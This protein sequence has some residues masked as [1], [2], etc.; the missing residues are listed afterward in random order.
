MRKWYLPLTVLAVAGFGTLVLS[1]R[2]RQ[3]LR[4]LAENF[5]AAPDAWLRWNDSTWEEITSLKAAVN[6]LAQSLD[7]A[8]D[9]QASL[10]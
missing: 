2:G 1:T 4:W 8:P 3:V 10:G 7:A 6:Q 5:D 9:S